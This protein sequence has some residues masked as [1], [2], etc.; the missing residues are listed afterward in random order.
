[1]IGPHFYF[2]LIRL[3]RKG[4]ST[5]FRCLYLLILLVGLAVM[6]ESQRH[7]IHNAGD[8]ARFAQSFAYTLIVL[9]DILVLFLLPVYVASA[10]AE[11]RENQTLEALFISPLTDRQIVLGKFGGRLLHLGAV[12]LA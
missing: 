11:E 5:F 6:Y 1:M 2:D 10:I 7:Y 8:Y 12:I 9:Q 3:P 4:W